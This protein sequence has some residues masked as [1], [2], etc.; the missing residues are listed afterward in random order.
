M[1]LSID[2]ILNALKQLATAAQINDISHWSGWI[3]GDGKKRDVQVSSVTTSSGGLG[4]TIIDGPST[5]TLEAGTNGV[6]L[7]GVLVP[8]ANVVFA[9]KGSL[10][11]PIRVALDF[12]PIPLNGHSARFNM[13]FTI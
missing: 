5:Y 8:G 11:H 4:L 13:R 7:D 10:A 2:A 12:R 1:A 3:T 6:S 9:Y